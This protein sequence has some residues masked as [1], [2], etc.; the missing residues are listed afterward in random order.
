MN[1][2]SRIVAYDF[3]E[4]RR[5]SAHST[6]TIERWLK[7]AAALA[8]ERWQQ[9]HLSAAITYTGLKSQVTTTALSGLPDPGWGASVRF[10][11]VPKVSI[12]ASSL[13]LMH[14]LV[15]HLL[16]VEEA[17]ADSTAPL[18]AIEESMAEFVLQEWLAAVSEAW[19][20]AEPLDVQY[21][22]TI[23]Q[24]RRTRV[25]PQREL[26]FIVSLAVEAGTH[27]GLLQWVLPSE[28][29]E[30]LIEMECDSRPLQP[31]TPAPQIPELIRQIPV[32]LTVELGHVDLTMAELTRLAIDDVLVLDQ[33][34]RHLL[35]ASV[36]E[37]QTFLGRPARVGQRRCL[38]I[39]EV[40]ATADTPAT[41]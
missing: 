14:G 13:P 31:V 6:Q 19:P 9:I 27:Q 28:A 16:G 34:A 10:G 8:A 15:S 5:P 38:Q 3:R 35:A 32:R 26:M 22:E 33:P 11:A 20:G 4:P 12:I 1:Q 24:P 23:S 25:L 7:T 29:V 41:R 37:Q 30:D 21:Q 39:E 18:T 36:G 40:L 17:E 2:S